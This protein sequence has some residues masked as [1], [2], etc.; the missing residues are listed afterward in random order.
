MYIYICIRICIWWAIWAHKTLQFWEV[1]DDPLIS[2]KKKH[3]LYFVEA[4]L[5]SQKNIGF[6]KGTTD[7]IHF[8]GCNWQ[9]IQDK[10]AIRESVGYPKIS[11]TVSLSQFSRFP[12]YSQFSSNSH[13]DIFLGYSCGD[14]IRS[15]F[16]KWTL[17]IAYNLRQVS[18]GAKRGRDGKCEI[19]INRSTE[20]NGK[21]NKVVIQ[22]NEPL[23]TGKL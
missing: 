7:S 13:K 10:L 2:Q 17:L 16:D 5:Y 1:L 22:D 18:T 12:R 20:K 4:M 19:L 3:K 21:P 8:L 11:G 9:N 14:M 6:I 23:T 15:S